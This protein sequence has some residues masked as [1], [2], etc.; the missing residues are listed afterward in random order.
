MEGVA[1]LHCIFHLFNGRDSV[2]VYK[3]LEHMSFG[4]FKTLLKGNVDFHY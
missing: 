4:E 3:Q 1:L 2:D